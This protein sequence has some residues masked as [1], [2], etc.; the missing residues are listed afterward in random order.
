MD[1]PRTL[2]KNGGKLKW[3]KD[4][5]YSVSKVSNEKEYDVAINSGYIDSFADALNKPVSKK[6]EDTPSWK[7]LAI[8]MGLEGE[9]L[10]KFMKKN[11]ANKKKQ[12]E[13]MKG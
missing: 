10:S 7:D 1:F 12:L 9:E 3:G 5:Y 8:E 4:K 11:T 2:Y 13:K 6:V